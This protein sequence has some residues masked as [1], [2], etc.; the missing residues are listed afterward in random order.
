MS[1]IPSKLSA[2]GCLKTSRSTINYQLS[3]RARGH[4]PYQLSTINRSRAGTLAL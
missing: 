2:I 3:G 1:S 4:R